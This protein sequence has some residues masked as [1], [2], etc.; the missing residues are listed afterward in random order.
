MSDDE[1]E[2]N[3]RPGKRPSK[4]K[5]QSPDEPSSKESDDESPDVTAPL[6]SRHKLHQ[7]ANHQIDIDEYVE[8]R[9]DSPEREREMAIWVN[10]EEIDEESFKNYIELARGTFSMPLDRALFILSKCGFDY[11]KAKNMLSSVRYIA[12][13][14][15]K[16]DKLLFRRAFHMYGKRFDQIQALMPHRSYRAVV[17]YYYDTKK[18]KHYKCALD[19]RVDNLLEI[20]RDRDRHGVNKPLKTCENCGS[21]VRYLTPTM[22]S[23]RQ[24]C[25]VCITFMNLMGHSRTVNVRQNYLDMKKLNVDYNERTIRYAERYRWM[26]TTLNELP[27]IKVEKD[28]KGPIDLHTC[29]FSGALPRAPRVPT[30]MVARREKTICMLAIEKIENEL[31][32]LKERVGLIGEPSMGKVNKNIASIEVHSEFLAEAQQRYEREEVSRQR[33]SHSWTELEKKQLALC[34]ARFGIQPELVA[35]ILTTKSLS[36]IRIQMSAA[37]GIKELL[38]EHSEE[39]E[40]KAERMIGIEPGRSS[41]EVEVVTLDD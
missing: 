8:R 36:Q 4:R 40:E 2:P 16:E 6:A 14:W 3:R 5:E 7:G 22:S 21:K 10:P 30:V 20:D 11:E 31:A 32:I 35:E 24:E 41:G 39:L 26:S 25:N 29:R 19:T 15:T 18:G 28:G 17:N 34:I 27:L 13:E 9:S 12:D 23:N 37:T 38:T 33:N 1:Y